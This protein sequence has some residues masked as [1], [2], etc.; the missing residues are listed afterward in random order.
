MRKGRE[1][2]RAQETVGQKRG[3]KGK[4]GKKSRR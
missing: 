2:T 4:E 3:K 1:K